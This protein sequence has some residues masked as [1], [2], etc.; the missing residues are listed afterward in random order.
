[1]RPIRKITFRKKKQMF[2]I[3]YNPK[4]AFNLLLSLNP[5]E[6]E[7]QKEEQ[8]ITLKCMRDRT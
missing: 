7:L 1:M 4:N 5:R 6:K 3:P 2:N 8:E